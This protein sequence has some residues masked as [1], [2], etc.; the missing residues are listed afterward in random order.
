MPS[1]MSRKLV[2]AVLAGCALLAV[3]FL[4]RESGRPD[5]PRDGTT[6]QQRA[7][8]PELHAPGGASPPPDVSS[9]ATTT[10]DRC[11]LLVSALRSHPPSTPLREVLL[12]VG[13]LSAA[14]LECLSFPDLVLLAARACDPDAAGLGVGADVLLAYLLRAPTAIRAGPIAALDPTQASCLLEALPL[15]SSPEFWSQIFAAMASQSP[16]DGIVRQDLLIQLFKALMTRIAPGRHE[17][18]RPVWIALKPDMRGLQVKYNWYLAAA[19]FASGLELAALVAE[20]VTWE[21]TSV[22]HGNLAL[23]AAARGMERVHLSLRG[24]LMRQAGSANWRRVLLLSFP[25]E[26]QWPQSTVSA[27]DAG[28]R[29]AIRA[30]SS[31]QPTTPEERR[32]HL[33]IALNRWQLLGAA[34]AIAD[35]AGGLPVGSTDNLTV[36]RVGAALQGIHMAESRG[37]ADYRRAT[38]AL[39]EWISSLD[40]VALVAALERMVSQR[41]VQTRGAS[42]LLVRILGDRIGD[43]PPNLATSIQV[44]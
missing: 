5:D 1:V 17:A 22:T 11:E 20:H 10:P 19:E 32:L 30:W 40:G 34:E 42:D 28:V 14:D 37:E 29:D 38:R 3:W 35:L 31:Q 43:L 9:Q 39:E 15:Q 41:Y 23:S 16:A 25:G 18:W 24:E 7:G 27:S 2:L 44:K 8:Q 36:A 4:F 26:V 33:E 13:R 21:N 6:P 12:H